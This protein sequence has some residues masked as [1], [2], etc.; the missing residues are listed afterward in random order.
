VHAYSGLA[1]L[2]SSVKTKPALAPLAD[3]ATRPTGAL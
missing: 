2:P 3:G 1:Q